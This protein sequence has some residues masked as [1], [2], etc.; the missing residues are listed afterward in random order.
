LNHRVH[1]EEQSAVMG[2]LLERLGYASAI[3]AYESKEYDGLTII[4]GHLRGEL[5]EGETMPVL[6]VD[7]D[8]EEARLLLASF[9][10]VG[11]MAGSDSEILREL[12]DGVEVGEDLELLFTDI[13]FS[14]DEEFLET[15]I[16]D[17]ATPEYEIAPNLDEG[18]DYVVI[19]CRKTTEM[20][21]LS[22]ILDLPTKEY[23]SG[24]VGMCRVLEYKEFFER[25]KQK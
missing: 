14:D 16:A 10:K 3:I 4:D 20:A 5:L 19:F 7:L 22:T 2:S 21:Q 18:Y 12:L 11:A 6:I 13:D 17:D 24:R 15:I 23:K 8:D 1:S 9:D 25:W